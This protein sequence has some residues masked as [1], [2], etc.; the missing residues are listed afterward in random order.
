M[1]QRVDLQTILETILGSPNVYFQPPNNLQMQYPCIVYNLD[2]I[3]TEY[4]NDD[5]HIWTKK[6]Q[7]KVINRNPSFTI[8]DKIMKLR[9][10]RY[11]RHYVADNLNHDIFDLYF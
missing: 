6:Y 5:P 2:D 10:V 9:M 4:A 1:G 7:L 3:Q 11:A 8:I